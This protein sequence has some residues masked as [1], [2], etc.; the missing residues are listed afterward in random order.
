MLANHARCVAALAADM[1][2]PERNI[3]VA[4]RI[5]TVK[6]TPAIDHMKAR[7]YLI[8]MAVAILVPAA[9]I[10]AAGLSML[11]QW[12]RDSRIRGVE[13]AARATVQMVDREIAVTDARRDGIRCF[14]G[15]A[16]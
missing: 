6:L 16:A 4:S 2:I 9:L 1:Q 14:P 8:L 11:L 15:R 3:Q 10:M 13:E 7:T 5:S 12:E